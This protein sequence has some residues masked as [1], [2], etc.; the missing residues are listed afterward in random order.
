MR[1][2]N[3]VDW[4]NVPV[5]FDIVLATRLLGVSRETI[6]KW[7]NQKDMPSIRIGR[8]VRFNKDDVQQWLRD[9]QN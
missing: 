5:L 7:I 2:Q 6:R 1:T 3:V 8:T 9:C 4:D